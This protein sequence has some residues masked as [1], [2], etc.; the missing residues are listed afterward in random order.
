MDSWLFLSNNQIL[1]F[2]NHIIF[3]SL[4]QELTQSNTE[5]AQRCTEQAQGDNDF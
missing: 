3:L 1:S 4:I 2:T 5:G